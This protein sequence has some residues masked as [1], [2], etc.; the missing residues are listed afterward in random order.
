MARAAKNTASA[1]TGPAGIGHNDIALKDLKVLFFIGRQ[2]YLAAQAAQKAANAEMKRV[3]KVIK[4]DLGEFGLDSIKAYE[5]AQT[6]EGKAA[7][8]ARQEAERQ[9]MSFAGIPINTQLDLLTDRM[10]LVER[11]YRDGEEAGLRGDTLNNPFSEASEEGH[12]Y[13]R[14][15]HDGQGALFAGIKQKEAEAAAELIK[16]PGHDGGGDLDEEQD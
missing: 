3:G 6:P 7:L 9:A 14:G 13:A 10:P 2:K 8:Q 12:E 16:G 5:K 15:W 11:A 1:E 4:V